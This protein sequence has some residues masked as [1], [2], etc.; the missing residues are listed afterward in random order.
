[1][2]PT[3]QNSDG[4]LERYYGHFFECH[5]LSLA[6][7]QL[8]F[9]DVLHPFGYARLRASRLMVGDEPSKSDGDQLDVAVDRLPCHSP[10]S[11]TVV[12]SL[13]SAGEILHFAPPVGMEREVPMTQGVT[14]Y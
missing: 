14:W 3:R 5:A 4:S 13:A 8:R 1:M 9:D 6:G 2:I 11:Y 7:L 10:N 12:R